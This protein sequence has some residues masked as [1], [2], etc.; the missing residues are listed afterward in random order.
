MTQGTAIPYD[1]GLPLGVELDRQNHV[2][3][4]DWSDSN[5]KGPIPPLIGE[6]KYLKKLWVE[7]EF[8]VRVLNDN[9]ITGP[10]PIELWDLVEL[11][12]L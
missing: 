5:L 9:Y 11:T 8:T 6:L 10:L 3:E 7:I 2:I 1:F 12:D 4:I